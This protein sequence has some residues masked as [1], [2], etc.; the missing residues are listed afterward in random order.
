MQKAV[1][2]AD[3]RVCATAYVVAES[4]AAAL[5]LIKGLHLDCLEVEDAGGEVP[6]SGHQFQDLEPGVVSLAPVMTIYTDSLTESDI[7]EGEDI[8]DKPTE[9]VERD[10]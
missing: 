10:G 4:A 3:I 8:A 7:E 1:F 6:I 9:P 5:I 2:S